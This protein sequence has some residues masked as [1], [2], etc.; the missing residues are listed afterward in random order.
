MA[1]LLPSA[2]LLMLQQSFL[3]VEAPSQI[4]PSMPSSAWN[5]RLHPPLP[6]PRSLP[7]LHH[8]VGLRILSRQFVKTAIG[9]DQEAFST[10]IAGIRHLLLLPLS[11]HPMFDN[12]MTIPPCSEQLLG[13]HRPS[14]KIPCTSW[15]QL[16]DEPLAKH[17]RPKLRRRIHPSNGLPNL[18]RFVNRR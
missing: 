2:V 13:S 18:R 10:A 9:Q 3:A 4:S 8:P 15:L 1:G 17:K 12:P 14:P 11:T 6:L 5:R 16:L 7:Q